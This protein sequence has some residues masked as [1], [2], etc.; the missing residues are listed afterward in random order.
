M[1]DLHEPDN[2]KE[3]T[4]ICKAELALLRGRN[5]QLEADAVLSERAMR[6]AYT[7]CHHLAAL[8]DYGTPESTTPIDMIELK[9]AMEA[10]ETALRISP[11]YWPG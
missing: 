1:P 10:I 2:Y 6:A 8:R 11:G 7:I 9:G 5:A 3:F 4:T